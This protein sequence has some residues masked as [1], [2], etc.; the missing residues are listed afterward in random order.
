MPDK[1]VIINYTNRDFNSIKRDLEN[2]ARVYYPDNFRD[3]SENSFGS[4][5]SLSSSIG[6]DL[7][8]SYPVA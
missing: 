7:L 6:T 8:T 5:I 3:F 2:H 1:K 4:F